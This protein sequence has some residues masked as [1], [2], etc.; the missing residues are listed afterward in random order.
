M[1]GIQWSGGKCKSLS[2]A[3]AILRH[4]DKEERLKR[5]HSNKDI[6]Q[7]LTARNFTYKGLSYVEKCNAYDDRLSSIEFGRKSKGKNTRVVMQS[8][9]IYAPKL[10]PDDKSY[11]WFMDVGK[12]LESEFGDDFIELDVHYDE[13]HEY[14]DAQ[15][16]DVI[17]SRIHGHAALVPSVNGK[18]NAKGFSSRKRIN[19]LNQALD[20]LTIEKYGIPYIEGNCKKGHSDVR[21]LKAMSEIAKKEM[22]TLIDE[23]SRSKL[24][25]ISLKNDNYALINTNEKM[26]KEL[27]EMKVKLEE[28]K[29]YVNKDEFMKAFKRKRKIKG[30]L[31]EPDRIIEENCYDA[32]KKANE[33]KRRISSGEDMQL[34]R[35]EEMGREYYNDD[36]EDEP[37]K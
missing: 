10:L 8:I 6:R 32:W 23:C 11:N 5:H 31:G 4:N 21:S 20:S 24:E 34:N 26:R 29:E 17:T 19:A 12:L 30:K 36:F 25:A 15:S 9:V 13:V 14:V 35:L 2:E 27:K 37:S 18:L 3:K 16:R 33:R 7:E 1:A 28:I 22:L